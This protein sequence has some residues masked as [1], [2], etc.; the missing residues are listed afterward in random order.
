M[1]VVLDGLRTCALRVTAV[2]SSDAGNNSI[3]S[4]CHCTNPVFVLSFEEKNQIAS[5][6]LMFITFTKYVFRCFTS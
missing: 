5:I 3:Y 6:G 4:V 2:H 1:D